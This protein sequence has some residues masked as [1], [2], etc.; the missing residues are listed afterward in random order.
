MKNIHDTSKEEELEVA[1]Y[2]SGKTRFYT[3]EVC[4][5]GQDDVQPSCFLLFEPTTR[6]ILQLAQGAAIRLQLPGVFTPPEVRIDLQQSDGSRDLP[7]DDLAGMSKLLYETGGPRPVPWEQCE[8]NVHE[9]YQQRVLT[10][11]RL[12]VRTH[13]KKRGPDAPAA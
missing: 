12:F 6:E 1:K 8:P 4:V 13:L 9:L 3:R 10:L 7:T 5:Y 2:P 11:W